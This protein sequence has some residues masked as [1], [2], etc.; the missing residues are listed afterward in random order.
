MRLEAE[1]AALDAAWAPDGQG[2][3]HVEERSD[4]GMAALAALEA[5]LGDL[6]L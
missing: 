6:E 3:E 2:R 1:L 4:A 5:R